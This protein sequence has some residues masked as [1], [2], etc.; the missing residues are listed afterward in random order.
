MLSKLQLTLDVEVEFDIL[1][2][3]LTHDVP[4]QVDITG[5]YIRVPSSQTKSRRVNILSAISESE[6]IN[7]E[8][9][10]LTPEFVENYFRVQD[11]RSR[12]E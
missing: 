2:P 8:D 10:I 4:L 9:E 11:W 7:L 3:L 5:A 1:D 6:I 12:H